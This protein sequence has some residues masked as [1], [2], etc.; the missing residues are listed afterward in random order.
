MSR[1]FYCSLKFL[2][3]S[4]LITPP[5]FITQVIMAG[6]LVIL[7]EVGVIASKWTYRSNQEQNQVV[8]G[9]DLTQPSARDSACEVTPV[10]DIAYAVTSCVQNQCRCRWEFARRRQA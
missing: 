5:D 10:A 9:L 6:P 2:I 8:L 3:L 1:I 7:Y 4:A